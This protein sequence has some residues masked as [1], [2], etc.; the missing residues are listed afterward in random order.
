MNEKALRKLLS[1]LGEAT[2][3]RER[4]AKKEDGGAI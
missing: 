3:N 1:L 4:L 2:S